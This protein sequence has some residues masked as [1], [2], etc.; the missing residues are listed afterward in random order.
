MG[1]V[2]V[3][4]REHPYVVIDKEGLNDAELSWKAKGLLAYLLSLPDGW[5][6][7]ITDLANRSKDGRHAVASG[8]KELEEAG[9]ARQV[10]ARQEGGEFSRGGW[11]VYE[12]TQLAEVRGGTASRFSAHGESAH[13]KSH[14]TKEPATNNPETN[15]PL[16]PS[17][18]GTDAEGDAGEKEKKSSRNSYPGWFESLWSAYPKMVKDRAN[19]KRGAFL[20]AEKWLKRGYETDDLIFAA[21]GYALSRPNPQ[22]VQMGQTFYGPKGTFEEY[23]ERG[24]AKGVAPEA[25]KGDT[26]SPQQA[27]R[28]IQPEDLVDFD[29]L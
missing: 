27:P 28:L 14:T 19:P 12:T 1:I 2:R 11:I 18:K 9:Y 25:K 24:R 29:I 3:E 16:V 23:V 26:S 7:N 10:Q 22:F 15:Q 8:L 13:G 5:N 21:I 17:A 4:R 20:A 6:I